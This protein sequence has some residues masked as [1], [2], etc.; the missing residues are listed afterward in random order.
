MWEK[1]SF[2]LC[3]YVKANPSV[4]YKYSKS[5]FCTFAAFT[6]RNLLADPL[7]VSKSDVFVFSRKKIKQIINFP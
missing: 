2:F 7:V 4:K 3:D 1:V 6:C 5:A